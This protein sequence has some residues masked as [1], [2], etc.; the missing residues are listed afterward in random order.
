MPIYF[1]LK[2]REKKI[3]RDPLVKLMIL[4]AG[5]MLIQALYHV[6]G[7]LDLRLLSKGIMEPISA[8]TLT[9]FAIVYFFTVK[10]TK[11]E[12]EACM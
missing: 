9:T 12:E 7:S 5:F 1:I 4:L 11:N 10:K 8:A 2:S 6:A 3:E